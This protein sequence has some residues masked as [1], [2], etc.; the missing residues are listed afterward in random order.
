M[1]EKTIVNERIKKHKIK[2]YIAKTLGRSKYSFVE[3]KKTPL[4]EKVIIHTTRPGLVVGRGGANILSLTSR[5]SKR[6]KLENPQIE[7]SEIEQPDMHPMSIAER[8]V[9]HF[10]RFGTRGFKMIGYRE[11]RGV[12][13]SGA[14]GAEIVITGRGVPSSRSKSWRFQQGYLKKSGDVSESAV[15]R[16]KTVANLRSGTVGVNVNILPADLVLPDS[17]TLKKLPEEEKK[18]VKPTK[19]KVEDKKSEKTT[20]KAKKPMG[21]E[22][23]KKVATKKAEVTKEN[24]V[25][26]KTKT[27]TAKKDENITKKSAKKTV[28]KKKA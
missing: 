5:L 11:L 10:D 13:E 9:S 23:S 7:V 4:G 20:K 25:K 21:K 24:K 6:F 27:T 15:L 16:A 26:T 18:E 12:M 3:I 22:K 1:I 2:E 28:A 17:I 8:I 19:E 14:L